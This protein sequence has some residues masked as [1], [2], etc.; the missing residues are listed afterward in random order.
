MKATRFVFYAALITGV[1]LVM[2]Y[3]VQQLS[4]GQEMRAREKQMTEQ[5]MKYGMP[6]ENHE[7]LKRY[8]GSWEVDIT[9]WQKP[10]GP[11]SK[12]KGTMKNDLILGGRY[13]KSEFEGMMSGMTFM[14][15]EIIGYDLFTNKYTTFWI[16]SWSTSFVWT[17]GTLDASGK[18]LSETGMFPDPLTDGRETQKVRNVTTFI[19]DGQYRFEMFMSL[20]DGREMKGLELLCTRIR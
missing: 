15:L 10:G 19:G 12:S 3:S 20:P 1:N 6:G 11:P 14:G 7:F 17:S 9:M 4:S 13:L 5:M 2:V 18:V 8:V 16:D